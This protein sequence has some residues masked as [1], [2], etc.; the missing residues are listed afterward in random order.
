MK[1]STTIYY[2]ILS[3]A[4]CLQLLSTVFTLSQNIGYGQRISLLENKKMTIEAEKNQLTKQLA[5]KTALQALTEDSAAEYQS[6]AEVVSVN[7]T[8]TSLALN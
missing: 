3:F 5:S 4:L 7:R 2:G 1:K 6:I 8:S